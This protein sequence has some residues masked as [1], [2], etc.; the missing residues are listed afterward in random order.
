MRK[1]CKN[2]ESD[3]QREIAVNILVKFSQPVLQLYKKGIE[4]SKESLY[5]DISCVSLTKCKDHL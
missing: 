2:K 5:T 4:S 1:G 3:H